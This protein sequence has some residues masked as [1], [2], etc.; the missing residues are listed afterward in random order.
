MRAFGTSQNMT[1]VA[2]ADIA[3]RYRFEWTDGPGSTARTSLDASGVLV[4]SDFAAAHRLKVA[5]PCGEGWAD[6]PA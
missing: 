5:E 2:P 4:A 6:G 3:G 1:G